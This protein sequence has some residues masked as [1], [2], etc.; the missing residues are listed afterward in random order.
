MTVPAIDT[1]TINTDTKQTR[2][3]DLQRLAN[4]LTALGFQAILRTPVGKQ[5]Y[6]QVS[7]PEVAMLTERIFAEAGSFWW[8]WIEVITDREHTVEAALIIAR[9]LRA[10]SNTFGE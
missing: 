9:V 1:D 3:T 4:E 10:T 5:P 8:S 7:N 2:Q 6:L